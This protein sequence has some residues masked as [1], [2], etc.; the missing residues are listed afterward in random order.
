MEFNKD[1]PQCDQV[2][3]LP[4]VMNARIIQNNDTVGTGKGIHAVK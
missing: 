2:K 1:T 4:W 3:S